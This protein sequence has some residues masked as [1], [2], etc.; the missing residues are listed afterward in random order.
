MTNG[1]RGRVFG[2]ESEVEYE[3][4]LLASVSIFRVAHN[5][6]VWPLLHFGGN[7]SYS[8]YIQSETTIIIYHTF[9]RNV[10]TNTDTV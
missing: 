6:R 9:F 1:A 7:G 8:C 10:D 3:M 5:P 4:C 2:I